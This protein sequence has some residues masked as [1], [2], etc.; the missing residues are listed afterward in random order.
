[1]RE[2]YAGQF[3][4]SNSGP[5]DAAEQDR[6]DV[7]RNNLTAALMRTAHRLFGDKIGS[8]TKRLARATGHGTR[9]VEHWLAD[10]REMSLPAFH[11]LACTDVAFLDTF[12]QSLPEAIRAQWLREQILNE[13]LLKAERRAADQSREIEQLRLELKGR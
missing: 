10:D 9:T 1:M 3:F 13:Q 12:M 4:S 5:H 11:R 8:I 6:T 7:R 2:A